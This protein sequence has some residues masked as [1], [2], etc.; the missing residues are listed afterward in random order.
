M[1]EYLVKRVGNRIPFLLYDILLA[2]IGK[3]YTYRKN[4]ISL[5]DNLFE[6]F[7][8][9]TYYVI[10]NS[11]VQYV[12]MYMCLPLLPTSFDMKTQYNTMI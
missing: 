3:P 6:R 10:R 11:N 9:Y 8:F 1:C 12:Y 5:R 2:A 7:N 4:F